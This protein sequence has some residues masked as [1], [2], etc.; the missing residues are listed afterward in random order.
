MGPPGHHMPPRRPASSDDR[1]VMAKHQTIYPNEDELQAVQNIVSATEKALK[2]VSDAI[3]EE[4]TPKDASKDESKDA[5][6]DAAAKPKADVDIKEEPSEQPKELTRTLKGVMRVGV[7]AKGLLLHGDLNVQLVVLCADK[8]T[9]RLLNRVAEKLPKFLKDVSAEGESYAVET[10]ASE[11]SVR[12]TADSDPK[13]TITITLTSPMMREG[14]DSSTTAKTPVKEDPS[15]VLDKA[16]CLTALAELRHAKW[17]QAR[18]NGLPSCVVLIR[19]MRHLIQHVSVLN[20]LTQ[21]TVEL[22]VEKC[23]SSGPPASSPGDAFRRVFECLASG[24]LLP[25]S[26]GVHD[27]CEKEPTDATANLTDQEREDVTAYAQN[28]LRLMAFRQIHETLM[29]DA[30]PMPR[31]KRGLSANASNRKRRRDESGNEVDNDGTEGVDGKK[32]KKEEGKEKM[33][34]A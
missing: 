31:Y 14:A 12:V 13:A 29:M 20:S 21:W 16:M 3:A 15:D 2:S 34:T 32:D 25:G 17:F 33:E 6:K 19:I 23:I 10:L 27:P 22:L 24:I 1:H 9:L 28:G 8:P 7:L 18:A 30:L 5:P 4:D 11:A 26:P